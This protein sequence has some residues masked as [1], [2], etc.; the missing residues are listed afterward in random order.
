M[1]N[2]LADHQWEL[3]LRRI[4]KGECTPFLGAGASA[5][6]LPLGGAIA[7]SWAE[8]H[9]YPLDD[10]YDLARVSHYLAIKIWREGI[11]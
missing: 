4:S 7:Q 9:G 11:S 3:L 8:E 6:T 5:G 1:E 2:K 10:V